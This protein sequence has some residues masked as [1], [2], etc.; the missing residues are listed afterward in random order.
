[1][2][3][4][5]HAGTFTDDDGRHPLDPMSSVRTFKWRVQSLSNPCDE[6]TVQRDFVSKH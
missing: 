4:S 5:H 3:Y 2:V 6:P 1:M